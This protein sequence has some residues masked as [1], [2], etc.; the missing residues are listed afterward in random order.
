MATPEPLVDLTDVADAAL[1]GTAVSTPFWV[2]Y[3]DKGLTTYMV[4]AG[5]VLLTLRC[6]KAFRDW[7]LAR[8]TYFQ[9]KKD[10][11]RQSE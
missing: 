7:R 1:G 8:Q 4:T 6:L 11:D 5:A 9:R 2:Q 10:D 3:L